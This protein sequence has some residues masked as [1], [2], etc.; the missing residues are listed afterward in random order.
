MVMLLFVCLFRLNYD[1]RKSKCLGIGTWEPF[2]EGFGVDRLEIQ[3]RPS[4]TN[5][6]NPP[7][8]HT[9]AV[10]RSRLF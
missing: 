10:F 7:V 2:L 8:L 1:D 9:F 5:V 6:A 4:P 3:I